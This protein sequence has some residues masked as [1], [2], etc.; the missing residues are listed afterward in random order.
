[1]SRAHPLVGEGHE[2]SFSSMGSCSALVL[3]DGFPW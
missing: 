3:V 2:M 1:L